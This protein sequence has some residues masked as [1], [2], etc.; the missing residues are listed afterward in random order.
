MEGLKLKEIP[1]LAGSILIVLFAGFLGSQATISQIPVWYAAL[2]KPLWAPPNWVFGPV[3]TTLYILMG[4]ALFLVLRKGW[5]R[6]DVKFAVLIFAV[7]LI[8]NVLWSVVFFSFHSL[9]GGFA[10]IMALW[11]AIFANLI[12]FYVI[13]KPAGLV[14]VPY[15]VWVSIA[16]YLNY[17]VYLLNP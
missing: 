15:I 14:L 5:Q 3:W 13:S 16:S 10:V 17:T 7:Q 8:L 4:I 2:A 11:L 12:A 1:M 9:L 6:Q